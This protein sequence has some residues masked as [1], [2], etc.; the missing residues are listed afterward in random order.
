MLSVRLDSAGP[1]AVDIEI[2]GYRAR[3][4]LLW[5][6]DGQRGGFCLSWLNIALLVENLFRANEP[7]G[8]RRDGDWP[9]LDLH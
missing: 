3:A 6:L 2:E 4:S 8:G 7:Q 9:G 5:R 1:D